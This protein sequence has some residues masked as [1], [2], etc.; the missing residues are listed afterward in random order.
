MSQFGRYIPL[1]ASLPSDVSSLVTVVQG[2]VIHEYMAKAYGFTVPESRTSESHLRPVHR[3]LERLLGAGEGPLTRAR[4]PENRLVGVCH[5][6]MLFLVAM[7]R[8]RG[9]PARGRCG[10]GT[11][12]N[13]GYFEDHWVTEYWNEQ[14]DRWILVDPQFDEVWRR[15]LKIDHD[16]MD[17]PRD[18]F[19]IAGDAWAKCR[20]GE[21]DPSKFGIFKGDLRGL[22]FIAGNLVRDVAALNKVEMLPW[23]MWGAMP[24]PDETIPDDQLPFFD[25]LAGLTREP[26]ENSAELTSQYE[27]DP[28]LRVPAQ[29]F[30]AVLK[31]AEK[32]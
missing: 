31:R 24:K 10:F 17:V 19:L 27:S 2:I 7:L 13:P 18:R 4:R 11:Y 6:F 12:F 9:I 14:E 26:D 29:V 1:I 21:A 32:L 28:R 8:A 25:L 20:A 23:D 3:M 16:I 5:H 22:W 30:N 15:E